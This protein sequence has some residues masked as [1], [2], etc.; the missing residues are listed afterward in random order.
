M[1]IGG[2]QIGLLFTELDDGVKI[3]FRSKGEIPVNELAKEFGGNGHLNA[4][5]ARTVGKKLE[6]VVRAVLERSLAYVK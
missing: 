2:V 6:D 4:S 3:S 5:G 1:R